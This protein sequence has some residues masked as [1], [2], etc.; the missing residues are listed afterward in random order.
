M[1]YMFF[2]MTILIKLEERPEIIM[3]NDFL[4]DYI[5]DGPKKKLSN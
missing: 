5:Y 2:I 4:L 3:F 1:K